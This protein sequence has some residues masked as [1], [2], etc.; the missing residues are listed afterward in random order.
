MVMMVPTPP[1]D[2]PTSVLLCNSNATD[3]QLKWERN[4]N[5]VWHIRCAV[6]CQDEYPWPVGE[7]PYRV[8]TFSPQS[9]NAGHKSGQKGLGLRLLIRREIRSYRLPIS[10]S[11]KPR[12]HM[13]K[14]LATRGAVRDFAVRGL[15]SRRR[16]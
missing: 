11:F 3:C 10:R 15:Q 9:H 2:L 13:S 7:H 16:V 4:A 6:P 14:T 1:W 12:Q 5:Y 8:L